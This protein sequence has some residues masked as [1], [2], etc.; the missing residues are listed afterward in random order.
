MTKIISNQ[1]NLITSMENWANIYS[2]GNKAKHW[3]PGRSAYSI[4]EY[5]INRN[6]LQRIAERVSQVLDEEVTF[7]KA[8]PEL[9][10]TFDE[11]GQGRVH[12]LGIYGETSSGKTLFIGVES[13][14]DEKFNKTIADVY[15]QAIAR[16][17]GG[18]RTKA[19]ERIEGLLRSH[20][21]KPD[22]NVFSLRYQLLYSTAGTLASNQDISVMYII[23][24]KTDLYDELKGLEN[25]KD[26]IAFINASRTEELDCSHPES[27]VHELKV[28][29]KSLY[30]VYE[31]VVLKE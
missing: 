3:K 19:P 12:D 22:K 24:F 16:R 15:L 17:I 10:L 1:G 27:I 26:Y 28:F 4:A 13:K 5:V 25:L 6:G 11:Y 23:V 18:G 8:I 30:A 29:R 20:F 14:V 9:E 21:R 7:E 2:A 31:Q